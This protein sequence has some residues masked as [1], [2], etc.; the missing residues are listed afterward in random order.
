MG[1]STS[2]QRKLWKAYECKEGALKRIAFGPDEIQVAPPTVD[3]W[4]AL[5]SVMQAHNYK[6]RTQ[7][8]A[9]YNCR[10]ITGG[11]EKSLHSYGIALDVN[12]DTN[13][14]KKTPDA[15][16]VRFSSKPT[17]EER[18]RDVRLQVA[19]TDM[20][21]EMIDDVGAIKTVGG[22]TV[23]EWGGHWS[24]IKDTMHFEVDLSPADLASGIDWTTVKGA[25]GG[26][27]ATAAFPGEPVLAS[28]IPP[29]AI[30]AALGK[31]ELVYPVIEKWEGSFNNDPDDPGGAT[32]MG[33]TQGDLERWRKRSVTVQEVEQLTREEARQIYR[34]YYWEPIHGDELPL[35]AAQV[36]YNSAVLEGVRKGSRY[37]QEALRQ[38]GFD[39]SADGEIGPLT[40][41]ACS[42]ADLKRLVSDFTGA[43]EAYLRSRPG[44]PKYGKGWLNR[45]NDVR[46]VAMEMAAAAPPPAQIPAQIPQ[47]QPPLYIPT[48]P[49]FG[50]PSMDTAQI[51]ARV[52]EL[53]AVLKQGTAPSAPAPAP[54]APPAPPLA[55][56]LPLSPIDKMLGGEAL[57]GKKTLL[58]VI[59]YVV[60]AVLQANGVVG[61]ATGAPAVP[62]NPGDAVGT[63]T[64]TGQI[65][66]TL[67]GSF[68]GLGLVSKV[69]RIIQV[70]GLIA[71]KIPR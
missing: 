9:S 38:Q 58:A 43:S 46:K 59:A 53:L 27:P 11:T 7:D 25:G 70:L 51:L 50:V 66:T 36:T 35:A 60:L 23:F 45:L 1:Q 14:F 56:M 57:A 65:L 63:A 67:I 40:I 18:A 49:P 31:F 19:D 13:P 15:R 44:F 29:A 16:K 4:K 55:E 47:P 30:G 8:T 64:V 20:T 41:A 69:D 37:L 34:A 39:I 21:P 42:Q 71:T 12:W 24:T 10:A 26:A 2:E 68:G 28:T 54:V 6:I 48:I 22:K 62:K 52:Q 32:N 17:Q 3:A 61:T 5:A 33:I